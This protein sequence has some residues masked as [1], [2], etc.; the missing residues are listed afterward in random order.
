MFKKLACIIFFA[1]W[2]HFMAAQT[3]VFMQNG[4][5]RV[6][7]GVFKDSE[8]GKTKG[9]YD[10]NEN[11]ILTLSVPGAKSIT[12]K[13][14]SFCTEKDNDILSI[15]DGKD[16]FA[17]LMGRWSGSK[18]PGTLVSKD[19]FITIH[20]KSDKSVACYG[21]EADIITAI[22]PPPTPTFTLNGT[23]KCN[24]T[25]FKV[26]SNRSIPCDSIKASLASLNGP[27]GSVGITSITADN[28]V[29]GK[30]TAFTVNTNGP[31]FLNGSYTFQLNVYW[32]D[33]CDSVYLTQSKL[34]FNVSDCPLKVILKADSDTICKGSCTFL[35][36]TVS[37]G[38]ASKYVYTWTPSLTGAGPHKI[39]PTI[40]T[41]Y[42]LRVT[43]GSSIP[44]ADTVDIAVLDPPVA[45]AD[46]E[47]C[48]YG[49]NIFLRATP[50][51]GKWMGTGIV[52]A[53]TGEFKTS[54]FWGKSKVWY[55]VGSCADTV[56]VN[57]VG[58]WNLENVFCPGKPPQAVWWFGPPGGTWSGPKITSA[59]I[60][61][62][63]VPGIYKDTYTWKGCKSVKTIRVENMVVPKFDTTCESR[64]SDTFTFSPKGIYPDWFPGL[65]N[66]Y[67]GWYNPSQMGG[68]GNKLIIWNG[69]GCKD[70]TRLTVLPCEAG[71]NDTFC[72]S[73]G[74]KVLKN[75]RPGTQYTWTGKGIINSGAP[76][77]DPGFFFALGK[78]SHI[79]TLTIRNGICT[80]RKFVYLIPTKIIRK[81][82]QFFCI[83]NPVRT[84]NNVLLGLS[85]DGGFWSGPGISGVN[86]FIAA[87]AGFGN[88]K[89][90]YNKN[91]CTDTLNAFVRPRPTAQNDTA[92]CINTAAFNCR[93]GE[94]GGTFSGKG[95]TNVI[96]GTFSPAVAGAGSH[97]I[98]FRNK[99]GCTVNFTIRVDV[100]PT[101]WFVNPVTEYC[102]KNTNYLLNANIP[103]GVFTGKGVTGNQFNPYMAGSGTHTL[104]YTLISGAC[105]AST[106][107][108]VTVIDTMKVKVSPPIDTICPGEMVWLRASAT[109]GD[110]FSYSF[111]WSNG[112]SGSGT[113]VSPATTT[114]YSVIVN[115]GCSEPA[116]AT[117]PIYRHPK[118]YFSATTSPAVCF[119]QKGWIKLKMKDNDPYRFTWDV[120][121]V[122]MGDSL[123]ALSGNL[124]RVT[125]V[126][127]KTGCTV[128]TS[129]E[130]PGF[131]AI[132]AAFIGSIPNG[133]NCLS[134]INPTLRI[135]NNC[136]GATTGT[137]YWGDGSS[138]PFDPSMSPKH[139]YNG[140]KNR[141]KVKLVVQNSGGC[142]DST[143]EDFCYRDTVVYYVPTAFTPNNDGFNDKLDW[144][145]IGATEFEIIIYN[146][147]GQIVFK[148]NNTSQ[149]WDGSF[150]GNPCPEG[151]YA[152]R[153]K[154][155]GRKTANRQDKGSILLLRP[156]N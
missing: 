47:I 134:P 107:L 79:D 131:K 50:A 100:A 110:K 117:V 35:R 99:W 61:T 130:I 88:H 155:K 90:V 18:G 132:T 74:L 20:F 39:C 89:L 156:K 43:D 111:A 108:D 135:F 91:G 153:I 22:I 14:K 125:A 98:T 66:S 92:V 19:S 12:L 104:T 138:E 45:M 118:A 83:E 85:P 10:H 41:R 27:F 140:D 21:W 29:G 77:Y 142:T 57:S 33:F 95:I 40:N 146:R 126:N 137:W 76:D 69:G 30:A 143:E 86:G 24:A 2:V 94:S 97:I 42:I 8:K 55:Q 78:A 70:T 49:P 122:Y 26:N 17:T 87:T 28:C 53:S 112:Q 1:G 82:T 102:F 81:D 148:S 149:F 129:I 73:A 25:S 6:C 133:A 63:D 7:K 15:F 62:P 65:T 9:D 123:S 113:F 67:W 150:Q 11:Y 71:P 48:Y 32:K 16:T 80:D 114:I 37:G 106:T 116:T 139:N 5:V 75:F 103:G 46:T 51:G 72:P 84:L 127:L 120:S 54:V 105:K 38:N 59:G 3:E 96:L 34:I 141:Y 115:D 154:F 93:A 109:G 13:F 152:Y 101:L 151:V 64:T 58:P 31:L 144:V 119:G 136:V 128:D 56:F 4:R 52:N 124:Y 147:W 68:A 145:L 44:S 121:P 36:A 60:F 23:V